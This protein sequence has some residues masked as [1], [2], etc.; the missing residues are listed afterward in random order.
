MAKT[1]VTK[2]GKIVLTILFTII[3]LLVLYCGYYKS[4]SKKIMCDTISGI[5]GNTVIIKKNK[6]DPEIIT[7]E[8]KGIL[9]YKEGDS[10]CYKEK[11]GEYVH[12]FDI[13]KFDTKFAI[14]YGAFLL[15]TCSVIVPITSSNKKDLLYVI[16]FCILLSFAFYSLYTTIDGVT[17]F[18]IC[19]FSSFCIGFITV[20][21]KSFI[22]SKNK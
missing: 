9:K 21:I 5:D 20:F 18:M 2:A 10:I 17:S 15:I 3:V 12:A 22:K 4:M 7:F 6:I 13:N 11:D 16:P 19:L 1:K 14:I 8:K